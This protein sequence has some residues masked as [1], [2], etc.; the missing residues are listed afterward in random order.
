[1]LRPQVNKLFDI[2]FVLGP[3]YH[4]YRKDDKPSILREAVRVTKTGGVIFAEGHRSENGAVL[5]RQ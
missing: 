4:L 5:E 2:V 1:M 3:M